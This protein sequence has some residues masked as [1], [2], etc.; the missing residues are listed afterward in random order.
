MNNNVNLPEEVK[1]YIIKNISKGKQS[2]V[3]LIVMFWFGRFDK[4]NNED[5]KNLDWISKNLLSKELEYKGLENLKPN[6]LLLK[7]S[8]EYEFE[9]KNLYDVLSVLQK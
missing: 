4:L 6:T 9:A 2:F 7:D 1:E 3:Y 8:A 5:K